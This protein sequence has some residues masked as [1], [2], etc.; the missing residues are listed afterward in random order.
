MLINNN[1]NYS[2]L[3]FY[4][5]LQEQNHRKP[6]SFGEIYPLYAPLKR[7]LPFQILFELETDTRVVNF[8]W[9]LHHL[10]EG[11]DEIVPIDMLELGQAI[12]AS[13]MDTR[14]LGI[15]LQIVYP[16]VASIVLQ[17]VIEPGQYYFKFTITEANLMPSDNPD[18]Y[19]NHKLYSE[20]FT[21]V[22]STAN[23]LRIEWGCVDNIYTDA[24]TIFYK[25]LRFSVMPYLYIATELGK[26]DYLFEDEGESRDGLFFPTKQLS[27]KV[28]RF[29]FVAPE[30]MCDII[31]LIPLADMIKVSD[32]YGRQYNCQSFLPTIKWLTQGNLASVECEFIADTIVKKVGYASDGIGD[33]NNDYNDDYAN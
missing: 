3:P 9:E 14:H 31:R 11:K 25:S 24:G 16:S 19:V 18:D 20:V 12:S 6:Y 26:P 2:V 28:Y 13:G 4:E 17:Q 15:M 33:F 22:N 23:F 8:R 1:N 32:P 10:A 29:T 27:K 30:Y 7:I 21:W 5:S